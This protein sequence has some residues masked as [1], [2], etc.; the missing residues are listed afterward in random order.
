MK[1]LIQQKQLST[2]NAKNNTHLHYMMSNFQ[3]VLFLFWTTWIAEIS[4]V[5]LIYLFG[6]FKNVKNIWHLTWSES[7]TVF[8]NTYAAGLFKVAVVSVVP[9]Q[10]ATFLNTTPMK[11]Y[12]LWIALEDATLE[13]GCLWFM[14][15]SH[16]GVYVGFLCNPL[17]LHILKESTIFSVHILCVK[18]Y[19]ICTSVYI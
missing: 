15:G 14:P 2:K 18:D 10:D 19:Y 6:C 4:S 8:I 7:S 13:N 11:L 17:S 1:T 12:G 5:A 16:K 3:N 9:H